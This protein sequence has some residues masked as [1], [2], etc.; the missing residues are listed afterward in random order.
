[1]SGFWSGFWPWATNHYL[2]TTLLALTFIQGFFGV[3]K[4]LI[5][6]W[7]SRR[8]KIKKP[9]PEEPTFEDPATLTPEARRTFW[10]RLR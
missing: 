5:P 9:S 3:V 8:P 6:G 4:R 1:M 7:W 2:L 10:D